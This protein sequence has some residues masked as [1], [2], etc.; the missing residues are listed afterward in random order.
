MRGMIT[1]RPVVAC[2]GMLLAAWSAPVLA[3]AQYG[4][5]YQQ[6]ESASDALERNV[7]TLA[8][9]PKDFNALIAAGKAA[10]QIGDPQAAAGFFAHSLSG[11]FVAQRG[12]V[13]S[14]RAQSIVHVDDLQ[15]PGEYGDVRSHEAV[16]VSRAVGV[17][18]MVANNWQHRTQG[19]QGLANVFTRNGM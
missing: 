14:R 9:D 8:T 19:V 4:Y 3:Q 13:R 18:V 10:I 2:A 12:F 6:A 15:D 16:G 1:I 17:L 5:G 7:R 11:L